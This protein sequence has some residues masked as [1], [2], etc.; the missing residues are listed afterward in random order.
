MNR[1]AAKLSS[2]PCIMYRGLWLPDRYDASP[3]SS[4]GGRLRIVACESF[5]T[6]WVAPPSI[7]PSMAAFTSASSSLRPAAA[8]GP[9]P[10]HCSQSTTPAVPSMS[11]DRK[12]FTPSPS[13]A[14]PYYS[15][16]FL[17]GREPARAEPLDVVV[18]V[19][20]ER[21]LGQNQARPGRELIS[22]AAPADA[23]AQALRSRH[24]PEDELVIGDKI[25][26]TGVDPAGHS[27]VRDRGIAQRG[28][29]VGDK[30]LD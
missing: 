26:G 17:P 11:V 19:L 7:A 24:G 2:R 29:A 28:H 30:V 4:S 9:S 3:A 12:T 15:C 20:P 27:D 21:E 5:T 18:S 23:D 6:I 25:V 16:G 13:Y 14:V 10:T 1:H 22:G 8:C